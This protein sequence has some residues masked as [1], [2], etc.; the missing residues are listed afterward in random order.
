MKHPLLALGMTAL[1]LFAV[2]ENNTVVVT[3]NRYEQP[4]TNTLAAVTVL[5]EDDIRQSGQS[6]LSSLLATVT[7][8]ANKTSGGLGTLSSVSARGLSHDRMIVLIDGIR[9]TNAT[10]GA[11]TLEAISLSDI[12]R[13]EIVRGPVSSLY[14][15]DGMGGVI[16]IFTKARQ[17]N[18]EDHY[19]SAEYGSDNFQQFRAGF[20]AL[21]E[22]NELQAGFG[23]LS[24]D[25][26][27]NTQH[28]DNGNDD[29]D[30]F[31]QWSASV[32]VSSRITDELALK[33]SHSQTSS[34]VEYDNQYCTSDCDTAVKSD[35]TLM[36]S[37]VSLNAQLPNNWQLQ[38]TVGRNLDDKFNYESGSAFTTESWSYNSIVS[39]QTRGL[40]ITIGADAALDDVSSTT[41]YD[42]TERTNVGVFSQ[43]IVR[44]GDTRLGAG[45]RFDANSD[46]GSVL[47]GNLSLSSFIVSDVEAIATYGTAFNAPSFDY[48]YYPGYSN[49][50]LEP[51]ESSTVEIALRQFR[52]DDYWRL[53]AY[54]TNA[55]NLIVSTAS[56]GYIPENVSEAVMQG[57]E[58]EVSKRLANTR[59]S[60]NAAYVDA[61]DSDD[62]QLSDIPEWTA[63][64]KVNQHFNAI[65][66]LF[67]LHG[68]GSRISS[69]ETLDGFVTLNSGVDYQYGAHA[70]SRLYARIDNILDEDYEINLGYNTPG[71]TFKVGVEYHL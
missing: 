46:F 14:G 55:D 69:S 12:E 34:I 1:P 21:N 18:S 71:R 65:G 47:T 52:G 3:A 15:A 6:D 23:H 31:D 24:T 54:R 4:I 30:G 29:K 8:L 62:N 53:S 13:I 56:T 49:P 61:K 70:Q 35:M 32:N 33:L 25:G 63:N 16:Q 68:E 38:S 41:E 5:T 19:V 37:S 7:G 44:L 50:D 43:G 48:L 51:E 20:S 17:V 45:A 26:F 42:Q 57:V 58:A 64:V 9:A 27:D 59:L 60:L 2:A 10:S 39:Q 28:T 66:V 67:E 36:T 40:E 11:T 22:K